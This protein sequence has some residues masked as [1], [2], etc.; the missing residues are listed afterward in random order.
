M[1]EQMNKL[2]GNPIGAVAGAAAG[3]FG[4]PKIGV[5]NTWAKVA[6]AVAG[7]FVGAMVQS[8]MKKP[9]VTKA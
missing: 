3:W 8:K 6:V 4:A 7:A 5:H 1:K 2:T 9:V